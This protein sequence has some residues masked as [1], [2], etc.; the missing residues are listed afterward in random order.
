MVYFDTNVYVYAF[1]QNVDNKSQ[2]EL[3]QEI[4]KKHASNQT[5]ILSE[6]ILYEFAF[7]CKKLGEQPKTIQKNLEF[8]SRYILP[9][10]KSIR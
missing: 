10:E 9:I 3:S 2:K 6:I 5:L 4:L 8:L 1:C 7:I